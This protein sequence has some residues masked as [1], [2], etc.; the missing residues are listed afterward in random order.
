MSLAEGFAGHGFVG[1]LVRQEVRGIEMIGIVCQDVPGFRPPR[2]GVLGNGVEDFF[3]GDLEL[4]A[5]IHSDPRWVRRSLKKQVDESFVLLAG[6]FDN[7]GG[8]DSPA[9]LG[10]SWKAW[11]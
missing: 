3:I 10:S 7:R 8:L 9:M 6:L 5:F 4:G 1:I 11:A 2:M